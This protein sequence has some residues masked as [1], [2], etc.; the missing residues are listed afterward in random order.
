MD[1]KACREE[2][3]TGQRTTMTQT[4]RSQSRQRSKMDLG[5]RSVIPAFVSELE[6]GLS[7]SLTHLCP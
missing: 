7:D 6:P 2:T 1:I 4:W 5:L 3:G